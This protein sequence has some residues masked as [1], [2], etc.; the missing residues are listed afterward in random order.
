MTARAAASR[1]GSNSRAWPV[2]VRPGWRSLRAAPASARPAAAI[3]ANATAPIGSGSPRPAKEA[4]H[5]PRHERSQTQRQCTV[6]GEPHQLLTGRQFLAALESQTHQ[7]AHQHDVQQAGGQQHAPGVAR[8]QSPVK[9]SAECGAGMN[10]RPATIAAH[11]SGQ[12]DGP[13][14]PTALPSVLE[15]EASTEKQH[16]PCSAGHRLG[17]SSVEYCQTGQC[18]KSGQQRRLRRARRAAHHPAHSA[19]EGAQAYESN[20]PPHPSGAKCNSG[21]GGPYLAEQPQTGCGRHETHQHGV[22]PFAKAKARQG[23]LRWK[24]SQAQCNSSQK[25]QLR[26]RRGGGER[27]VARCSAQDAQGG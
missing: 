26:D 16:Q 3:A 5:R 24:D 23:E 10:G 1:S 22:A 4:E 11:A 14:L 9:R 2:P 15:H 20:D 25:G 6:V 7:I 8:D 21:L 19:E 27:E 17:R 18:Q 13:F 12:D